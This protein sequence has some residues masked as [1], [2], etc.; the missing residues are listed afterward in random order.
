V[1]IWFDGHGRKNLPWQK[2]LSDKKN[3]AYRVWLSEIMLQQTQ[4]ATV[5][6]Y[7]EKFIK[8][9][10]TVEKLAAAPLDEVLHLWSGLGYYARARNLHKAANTVMEKYQGKFPETVDE[11]STLPGV[12]ASTAG[13]IVSIAFKKRGVILDGNVKRVLGRYY[14]I[15]GLPNETRTLERYWQLADKNT[16]RQRVHHYTQAIMDLGATLCT[17]SKPRCSECPLK[18]RCA[19]HKEG[20][21]EN[22]PAKKIKKTIP[23]RYVQ[24]LLLVNTQGEVLLEQ[25]PPQGIWGGLWSFPE[26]PENENLLLWC[27]QK[28]IGRITRQTSL[29]SRRHSFSHFHLTIQPV[30][31]RLAAKPRTEIMDGDPVLWY[32][33]VAPK[34]AAL[35]AKGLAAPVS[36]LLKQLKEDILRGP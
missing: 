13:A 24:M 23:T 11:L 3:A 9:F 20:K 21:P 10:P 6:P 29:P 34:T 33:L 16:P 1:L 19:A 5:I 26:L 18:R 4:V 8:K 30:V 15:T 17:R 32:K 22:Y 12:G 25:R 28:N 31:L 27:A 7:F 35:P 14:A 36:K 2:K